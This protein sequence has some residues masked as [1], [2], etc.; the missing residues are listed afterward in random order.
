MKESLQFLIKTDEIP[1]GPQTLEDLVSLSAN[2]KS[3]S[4]ISI[5]VNSELSI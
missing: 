5:G 2:N 4:L 1:S 3:Y